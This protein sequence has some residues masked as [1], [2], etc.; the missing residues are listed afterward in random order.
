MTGKTILAFD[1][2][3][4]L[5]VSA[6]GIVTARVEASGPLLIDVEKTLIIAAQ[7]QMFDEQ[8]RHATKNVLYTSPEEN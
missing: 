3:R 4:D 5:P 7:S 2:E 1:G 6:E 8:T